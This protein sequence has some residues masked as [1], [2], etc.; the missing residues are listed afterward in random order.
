MCVTKKSAGM[1]CTLMKIMKMLSHHYNDCNSQNIGKLNHL[2]KIHAVH[3][4]EN[5][6]N[7]LKKHLNC[8]LVSALRFVQLHQLHLSSFLCDCSTIKSILGWI[9]QQEVN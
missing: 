3:P 2:L 4:S 7:Y 9:L 8:S 5:I 1:F 6:S